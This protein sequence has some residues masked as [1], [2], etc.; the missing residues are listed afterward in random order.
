MI[1]VLEETPVIHT[2]MLLRTN[3]SITVSW[4]EPKVCSGIIKNYIYQVYTVCKI[5]MTAK[6]LFSYSVKEIDH[7]KTII[8]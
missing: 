4:K 5:L 6:W 7:R 3:T 2:E 8:I 1:I